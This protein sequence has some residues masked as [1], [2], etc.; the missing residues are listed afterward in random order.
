MTT[1]FIN[2]LIE[3]VSD[4]L[5]CRDDIG[6]IKD[7]VYIVSHQW[8]GDEPGRGL[9]TEFMTKVLPTPHVVDLRHNRTI[10]AAGKQA[11]GDILVKNI[12]R[13]QFATEA[14]VDGSSDSNTKEVFYKIGEYYYN[15]ISVKKKYATWDVLL[16]K[17]SV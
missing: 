13:K 16:V 10:I 12:S 2:D 14:E 17:A 5:S 6:A 1:T 7:Y 3:D 4:A 15:V 11:K 8:S 9:K